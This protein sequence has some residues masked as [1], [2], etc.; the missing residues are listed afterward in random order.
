MGNKKYILLAFSLLL[1]AGCKGDRCD[2]PF[3][4]GGTIN[5]TVPEFNN[6]YNNP[7]ATLVINRG[8]RGILVHCVALGQYVA[9]ECACPKDHDTRM[10]PDD[11]RYAIILTCPDCGSRFELTYGNPLEGAT[12]SCPLYA[13]NTAYDGQV[14][15][16]W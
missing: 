5:L 16:I 7:G 15:E 1:L 13:Y 3:G 8:Y 6:L 4:E 10:I 9:F 12:T 11:D 2:T 14:L